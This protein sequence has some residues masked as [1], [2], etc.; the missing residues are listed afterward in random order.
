MKH[1]IMNLLMSE[2]QLISWMG[3]LQGLLKLEFLEILAKGMVPLS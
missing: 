2:T 1:Q 3:L